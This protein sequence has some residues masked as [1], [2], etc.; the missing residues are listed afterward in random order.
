MNI[1]FDVFSE[2]ADFKMRRILKPLFTDHESFKLLEEGANSFSS[3]IVNQAV[4]SVGPFA[5]QLFLEKEFDNTNTL[6]VL[7]HS[8]H[9]DFRAIIKNACEYLVRSRWG[10]KVADHVG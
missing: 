4:S 6:A 10:R 9:Y 3:G 5:R 8:K 7:E 1:A 2:D